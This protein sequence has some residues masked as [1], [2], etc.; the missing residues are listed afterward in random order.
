MIGGGERE[1]KKGR[2]KKRNELMHRF[3]NVYV[4]LVHFM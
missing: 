1:Y 4:C 3:Y 2:L